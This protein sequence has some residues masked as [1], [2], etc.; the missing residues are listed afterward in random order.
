MGIEQTLLRY[1]KELEDIQSKMD[2]EK[3]ALNHIYESLNE[4]LEL[5]PEEHTHK[6]IEE[7]ANDEITKLQKRSNK[8]SK[9]LDTLVE[10]IEQ[11]LE[12]I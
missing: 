7:Y 5:E 6:E 9:Q 2:Q 3:G 11:Q 10:E 1:K 12:E 4:E 8:L